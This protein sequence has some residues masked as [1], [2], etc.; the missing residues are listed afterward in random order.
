MRL[1]SEIWVHAL[2]RRCFVAGLYGAVLRNGAA[3]AGAIYV[4]I[5][6]LDGTVKVL[7][8]P[9]GSAIDEEGERLWSE[10]APPVT[11]PADVAA[12]IARVAKF[13]P[14]IWVVEIEDRAGTAGLT[15]VSLE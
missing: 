4:V 12:F 8:P 14:D 11:S 2:L 7:G 13:D 5:D 1:K 10:V 15:V 6:R 9:P 3:E